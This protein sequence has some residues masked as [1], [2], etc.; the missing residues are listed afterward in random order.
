MSREGLTKGIFEQRPAV[1]QG[2]Q[3]KTVPDRESSMCKGPEV[4]GGLMCLGTSE[5]ASVAGAA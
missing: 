2:Y 3:G 4:E 1:C 5:E